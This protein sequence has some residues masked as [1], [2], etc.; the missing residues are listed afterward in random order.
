MQDKGCPLFIS[1]DHDLGDSKQKPGLDIVKW[2]IE[3]DLNLSG[4]FIPNNFKFEVHSAN[5]VGRDK[6]NGLLHNYLNQK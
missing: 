3:K 5:P 1:F 2:M 4:Q 6:I